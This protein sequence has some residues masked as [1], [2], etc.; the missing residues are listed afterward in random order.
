MKFVAT[1]SN[2]DVNDRQTVSWSSRFT[3]DQLRRK[4]TVSR[5]HD[6]PW[7]AALVKILFQQRP[8]GFTRRLLSGSRLVS[9]PWRAVHAR[10][11]E[12]GVIFNW[13]SIAPLQGLNLERETR[14]I[15]YADV[16]R[17]GFVCWAV[18]RSSMWNLYRCLLMPGD[19]SLVCFV[20]GEILTS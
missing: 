7:T 12:R 2:Y 10:C 5:A 16:R 9:S 4:T 14:K 6:V 17:R 13:A 11:H 19:F 20:A 8:R 3:T 15:C 1:R 18:R